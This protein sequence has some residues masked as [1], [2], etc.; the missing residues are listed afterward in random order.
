M[1]TGALQVNAN[2]TSV[3]FVIAM[4]VHKNTVIL[5]NVNTATDSFEVMQVANITQPLAAAIRT[6]LCGPN[7]LAL[8]CITSTQLMWLARKTSSKG[9]G[10]TPSSKLMVN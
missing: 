7:H 2:G 6:H 8:V 10:A 4:N 9:C 3:G 1:F 5:G